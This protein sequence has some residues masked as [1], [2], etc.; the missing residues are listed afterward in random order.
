MESQLDNDL[1][2][3]SNRNSACTTPHNMQLFALNILFAKAVFFF[4]THSYI[5]YVWLASRLRHVRRLREAQKPPFLLIITSTVGSLHVCSCF[6]Y[7]PRRIV[8]PPSAGTTDII[9]ETVLGSLTRRFKATAETA[10]QHFHGLHGSEKLSFSVHSQEHAPIPAFTPLIHGSAET[11]NHSAD[12]D[13]TLVPCCQNL[14]H[15]SS[16]GE[17]VAWGGWDG[18]VHYVWMPS[19]IY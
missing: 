6:L 19:I 7:L 3:D 9:S 12:A 5:Q 10:L 16:S 13:N 14:Y 2:P 15:Y 17:A 4:H 1:H 18:F 8:T 11:K